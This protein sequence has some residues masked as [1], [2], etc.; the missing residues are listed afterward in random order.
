MPADEAEAWAADLRRGAADGEWFFSV[1]RYLFL[2][3]KP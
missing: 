2:A 3:T 1:N